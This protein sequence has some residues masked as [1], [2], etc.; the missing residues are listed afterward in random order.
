LAP[1]KVPIPPPVPAENGDPQAKRQRL[2]PAQAAQINPALAAFKDRM[3]QKE[4]SLRSIKYFFDQGLLTEQ[5][6]AASVSEV[7]KNFGTY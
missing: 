4:A 2:D 3:K 6:R 1:V 5:E 7:M